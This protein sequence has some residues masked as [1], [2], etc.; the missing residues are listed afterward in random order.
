M[1]IGLTGGIACG[2]STVAA[3]LAARGAILVDADAIAREVVE[4]GSPALDE[5]AARFGQDVIN[6]DGSLYRKRLGEIVFADR[7]AKRDLE[8]I[9]HPRIRQIMMGRMRENESLY[10]DKLVVV[11]VPLLYESKLE[12]W[13]SE[14][15]VVYVP[16]ETQ[17]TRLIQRDGLTTEQAESRLSAQLPIDEKKARADYV[18]DNQG[19]LSVT[20]EQVETFLRGK[21]LL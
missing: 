17:L 20:E 8:Q 7:E 4:P 3:M 15:M 10:P 9:L 12:S 19:S 6:E 13:F 16:R 1:N 18:I 2:K 21:G 14:V 5:I 11:D